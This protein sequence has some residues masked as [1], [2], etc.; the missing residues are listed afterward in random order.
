MKMQIEID[1]EMLDEAM[2]LGKHNSKKA[3]VEAAIRE[4]VAKKKR[5]EIKELFGTVEYDAGYDY[6]KLRQAR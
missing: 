4:Y 1:K 6:K 2:K 3:T 5:V